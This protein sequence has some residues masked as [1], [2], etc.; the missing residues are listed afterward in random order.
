VFAGTLAHD[1][2]RFDRRHRKAPQEG[3]QLCDRA[4]PD[5]IDLF[6]Q[7]RL[8]DLT[9]RNDYLCEASQLGCEGSRQDAAYGTCAAVQSQLAQ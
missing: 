3:G 5:D 4:K 7:F 8:S 1:L 9:Q 6:D 2:N